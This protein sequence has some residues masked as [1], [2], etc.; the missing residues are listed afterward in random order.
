MEQPDEQGLTD[1]RYK[2]ESPD[3]NALV[4]AARDVGYA[5]L[6]RRR[7]FLDLDILG[8][9]NEFELLQL[10]PFDST[11]KRMSVIV[12]RFAPWND[13]VLYSKGADNV[14]LE[15]LSSGQQTLVSQTKRHLEEYSNEGLRCL[16]LGFKKIS[17]KNYNEWEER[18][19]MAST[20]MED[21][22]EQ[23][24]AVQDEMER[25]LTL[26]GSTAIE[27]KLQDQVPE[28]IASLREAGIKVWVL[29]GDKLETAINIGFAANLLTSSM[30]L[31]TVRGGYPKDVVRTFLIAAGGIL[32][33]DLVD[34]D[35]DF[36]MTD[37]VIN[38]EGEDIVD[39]AL[40]IDGLALKH[41]FDNQRTK[42]YLLRIAKVCCSVVCCR[43]SPLQKAQVVHFVKK[44]EKAACL[45]IGDGANDVSM[46]QEADVGV[47]IAGKEGLQAAMASDYTFS[48]FK[49]LK[50]LLLVH[51]HWSYMRTSE[52]ILNF[53]FKNVYFSIIVFFYQI[54][55]G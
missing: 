32:G 19:R 34:V 12:R 14:I 42:R 37:V 30:T 50:P 20:T 29:T 6:G 17:E 4:S 51:G 1:L 16:L 52:M 23:I 53:F 27:D 54:Y 46:I 36:N 49:F 25:N 18:Y 39:H 44:G 28:C 47:A 41:I 15:R 35:R 8:K 3:E 24:E 10:F 13:I 55:C 7:N 40:V 9:Q 45:A 2:A 22:D 26:I 5:Y 33:K 48:Q 21:R 38:P 31:W 43:V 11:R